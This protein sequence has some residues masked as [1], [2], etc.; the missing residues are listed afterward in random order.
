MA[1]QIVG[2]G[3]AANDASGD[4]LRVG[5][6]KINDNFNEIYTGFGNGSVLNTTIS[7]GGLTLSLGSTDAT[8]AFNLS[9]ATNY[10]TSSL[11]GTITNA[12]LAGSIPN[13]KIATPNIL[14]RG[15][16]A[17]AITQALGGTLQIAG[18]TGITTAVSGNTV[19]ITNAG[20]STSNFTTDLS[21]KSTSNLAEGTNLYYTDARA[22]ARA[23]LKVDA[24]IDSSP[25]ALDTLNE[26]AAAIGDDANFSTTITNSIATKL[27]TS[28]FNSTFDP[29]FNT[30]L[31]TKDTDDLSE[32]TT[33]LYHT[34]ARA[35]ARVDAGFTAKSTTNLSEG[36]N[37]YFT[38]AR[39]DARITNALVDED[40][41][42]SNSATKLPSQQSVKAY[43]D[44]QILTKDNSD[45]IAE[46]SSNLYH[47]TARARGSISVS[48]NLTY[49]SST[50][51]V[52]FAQGNSDS[53][54]EG[55]S[56]LYHTNARAI[57]AVTGSNLD[58]G[59]NNITT[60]GQ[61]LF[62]NMFATSG[63]LPSATTYHGMFAHVH[64]TGKA[65]FAHAGNWVN[66]LDT[67]S[68][69]TANLTE[70]TNLYYTDAR[71]NTHLNTGTAS[72]GNILSWNGS[73]YAWVADQTGGGG[74]T[75]I[76]IQDEGTGLATAASVINFVGAGVVASGT[77][78][79]KTITVAGGGSAITV[80]EEGSDLNTAAEKLNF[81]GAGVTASGTGTTKTITI[82]NLTNAQ[83]RTA[84]EAATDSNVFTDAD[85]TKLGTVETNAKDD[86][87]GGE[88][89]AL[90]EAQ[91]NTNAFTDADNVKLGTVEA[92]AS[93][94]QTDAEIRAAVEA[95]TDSNVFTD[96][97]HT[98]L[99]A[100]EASADITDT[101]N[102]VAALTAGTNISI[103]AN[104]VISVNNIAI[105]DVFTV[106]SESTQ[107]AL[108][109]SQGDVVVRTDQN[110]TYI[111]NGGTANS[112]A[113]F[114][115]LLVPSGGV[116]S[117]SGHTGVISATQLKTAYEALSD[118][119]AFTDADHTKLDAIEASAT[120]DQTDAEI[121]TAVEAAS[122]SNVFTDADHTKLNAIEASATADQTDAEIRTA[123]EAASDSNVFTDADHTKLNAIEA[124]ADVTDTA[125]VVA[126][127]TAG[128]NITIANDGT[129]ASSGGGGSAITIQ[130][131]GSSLATAASTINFVGGGITASGTGT[132]KTITVSGGAG[133]EL[134]SGAIV[135]TNLVLTKTDASTVS[136]D[137]STLINPVGLVSG[138]NQWYISYGTNA[139]DAV[140]VSTTTSAVTN[141]G[142][143][144]WGEEL[145]RGS[146]YNFNMITDRQFRMGIWDGAQA[147]QTYQNQVL[148]TN[149]NTVFFFK[150]GTGTFA[151]S[152]NTE[153][154]DYNSGSE[155]SVANNSP[156]SLRFLS[157]GHLELVD[158][159]GGAENT[160]GRTINP[161][162]VN[163]FKVQFG[164]WS[165]ATF[166]N[167]SI[168]NTNFEWEIAH[169]LDLSE[170]G[171]KNGVENHTVIKSGISI[172][173]GE[174]ININLNLVA[175]G[176]YFGTNYTGNLTGVTDAD[177]LLV[178]RFQYQTNES[179]IG[180]A[181][182]F[183]TS[184]AGSPGTSNDGYFT[185]GGGSIPSYRRIG[186]NNPVGMISL[187]YY[188]DNS[189]QIWSEVENELIATA[190]ANG[191]GAPIHL[192]HGIRNDGG[193][194]RTYAQ[195]PSITKS[196]IA[197]GTGG[198]GVGMT[199]DL[200][201]KTANFSIVAAANYTAYLVSTASNVVTAT[202]PSSPTNGQ[203]V[204]L[205]D[206]GGNAATNNITIAR[207]GN[208]IQGGVNNL[209]LNTNRT[210][211]ELLFITG[212]GWIKSDNT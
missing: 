65:Y 100:I 138:S 154:A 11:V 210:T 29:R 196:T 145:V 186:V 71:V 170:D 9:D 67:T 199:T 156:L 93:A 27:T 73:D 175:R 22:D 88:I 38:N 203:R 107:L 26:L 32:G 119:N 17:T 141:Q 121:R 188:T 164:A 201:I 69:T 59:S 130:E 137:A 112:M 155:Y 160:I 139:D 182:N 42:V 23:Q 110:K 31:G 48:G 209:V 15:D 64:A 89:K 101:S 144:Y 174:Q 44:S 206:I 7:L 6:T 54:A 190:Q 16:A 152:T 63:D 91:S 85:H 86:L 173:P 113:D 28:D 184:A 153:V 56:N 90:Y 135:G 37:L 192:F 95:A 52:G 97:D 61:L 118:T 193:T 168:T 150:D 172:S 92:N 12:Q 125:N 136:I 5:A 195:I 87:S 30:Q 122:D 124:S 36:T 178:N 102:V 134:A 72:S 198:A 127:L 70:G 165:N 166:P 78:T 77:G 212:S 128:S 131:E 47:T 161:L 84:V 114:T 81:V 120:A 185:A 176:D 208:T 51:V 24:L 133:A 58:M 39:A 2:I 96:A 111:D 20:Y 159:T 143:Y 194:G 157:D 162:S 82:A 171:V 55:S 108:S 13:S 60:T 211:A 205:I 79:T 180:P 146:E 132:T 4:T 105:T 33:N 10:P 75:A 191:S 179:I 106:G 109:T 103:A 169:D 167:G 1:K 187:R 129:I 45:E 117:V 189:I 62:K 34:T 149:W 40:N 53:I 74:G 148:V 19:T 147:A 25:G 126:A 21:G 3:S 94:D 207:G 50:G 14:F 80:Q 41:M 35:D 163:S 197:V 66:L 123:V 46:G 99:N 76:T 181:Y 202:L 68:S 98:K 204:K 177:T 142:P 83:V 116:T 18:G 104:G 8:P 49:N 183:N 115:E 140:G 151:D 200:T 43:V 57:A 158:K